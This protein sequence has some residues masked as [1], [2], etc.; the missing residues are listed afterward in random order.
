MA[1]TASDIKSMSKLVKDVIAEKAY[2]VYGNEDKI[3]S[4]KDLFKEVVPLN[5]E[6]AE[7]PKKV[8]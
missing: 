2:C 3:K 4:E 7:L 6:T 1:T 5:P 8:D